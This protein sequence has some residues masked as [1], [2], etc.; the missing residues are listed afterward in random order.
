M[1][2]RSVDEQFSFAPVMSSDDSDDD[3]V[4]LHRDDLTIE[5]SS[6]PLH[7]YN[8]TEATDGSLW[9]QESQVE[10]LTSAGDGHPDT[11]DKSSKRVQR[12]RSAKSCGLDDIE[13]GFKSPELQVKPKLRK[14]NKETRIETVGTTRYQPQAT[15]V[16]PTTSSTAQSNSTPLMDEVLQKMTLSEANKAPQKRRHSQEAAAVEE[17]SK[18]AVT[19]RRVTRTLLASQ[20][21]KKQ[22]KKADAFN[23][24]QNIKY[25]DR[26]T[27]EN[28]MGEE[29]METDSNNNLKQSITVSDHTEFTCKPVTKLNQN[30]NTRYN[31]KDIAIKEEKIFGY[32]HKRPKLTSSG[33]A[34]QR[35]ETNKCTNNMK[36]DLKSSLEES[37]TK[38][39]RDFKGDS[40]T[41]S[42]FKAVGNDHEKD[43]RNIDSSSEGNK[44]HAQ[45]MSSSSSYSSESSVLD[46]HSSLQSPSSVHS[47]IRSKVR[48]LNKVL[49]FFV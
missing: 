38:C 44:C 22:S 36:A 41:N 37:I 9:E 33:D 32:L 21:N 24:K 14:T 5:E 4:L 34:S 2:R 39:N 23:P 1:C 10:N 29:E 46:S 35:K 11:E 45:R 27:G 6:Q 17:K 31:V 19:G 8:T 16:I 26:D 43:L 18:V 42:R 15:P 40:V 7:S 49:E 3:P 13:S 47:G 48:S 20:S 28:E 30:R 12:K 25:A